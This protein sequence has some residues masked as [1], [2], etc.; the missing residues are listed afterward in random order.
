VKVELDGH[1]E[2]R[3]GTA[4]DAVVLALSDPYELLEL[5]RGM[6]RPISTPDCWV[7]AQVRAGPVRMTPAVGVHAHREDE[8]RVTITGRPVDGHTPAHLD[9]TL[10]VHPVAMATSTVASRWDVSV[11]V[12]GPQLL[13]SSVRPLMQAGSRSVMRQLADRL[14]RRFDPPPARQGRT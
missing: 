9:L 13:A 10:V 4:H 1:D 8:R 14:R 6:I 3:V 11:D 12:P 5:L 2:V 7:M